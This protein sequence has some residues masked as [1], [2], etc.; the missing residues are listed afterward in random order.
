MRLC[1]HASNL[2]T[3]PSYSGISGSFSD[4]EIAGAAGGGGRMTGGGL[5]VCIDWNNADNACTVCGSSIGAIGGVASDEAGVSVEA[6]ST[7]RCKASI[8]FRIS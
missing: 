8:W 4:L 2:S 5:L 1:S 3:S 6:S 7:R